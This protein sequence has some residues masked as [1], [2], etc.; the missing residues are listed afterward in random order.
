MNEVTVILADSHRVVMEGIKSALRHHSRFVV[1]GEA[2]TGREALRLARSVKPD[3]I[4]MDIPMPD[5]IGILPV[6]KIRAALPELR[7]IIFTMRERKEYLPGL[8]RAGITGYV[9]KDAQL[10]ELVRAAHAVSNGNMYF[11]SAKPASRPPVFVRTVTGGE[12]SARRSER[13]TSREREVFRCIA[14]GRPIS[15]IAAMLGR[16][17]KTVESQKYRIME[18]LNAQ[19]V[20]DLVRIAVKRQLVRL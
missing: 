20:S 11:S 9:S 5:F 7:I 6:L 17:R 1:A 4:I 12:G 16:S 19:T 10:S 8:I 3:I 15:E 2:C 18:K 13:L 14:D